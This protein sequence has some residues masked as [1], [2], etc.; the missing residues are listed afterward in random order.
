M[1]GMYD[2]LRNR[3]YFQ[4]S[5]RT[6]FVLVTVLSVWLGYQ[7]NW[8]RERHKALEEL[9]QTSVVFDT[10]KPAPWSI[11]LIERGV[12][13]IAVN[14]DVAR[15]AQK[16]GRLKRLFPEAMICTPIDGLPVSRSPNPGFA[17]KAL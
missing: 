12:P 10:Y 3:R 17:L 5:L 15:D 7:L 13:S 4:F 8:I 14:P 9:Q 16:V 6:L 11:R 2:V 1:Q